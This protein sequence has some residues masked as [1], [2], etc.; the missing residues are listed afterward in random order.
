MK[1]YQFPKDPS[2]YRTREKQP[3]EDL[4]DKTGFIKDS[5]MHPESLIFNEY[6][7]IDIK[8]INHIL[9]FRYLGWF[10]C[11]EPFSRLIKKG[12]LEILYDY[13]SREEIF[14]ESQE[15]VFEFL[16]ELLSPYD[17]G[18]ML[19]EIYFFLKKD[20]RKTVTKVM[21]DFSKF[22]D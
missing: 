3:T 1:I 8:K 18:F 20:D 22:I 7:D 11:F 13:Y 9:M 6:S 2:K 10:S 15:V 14:N 21:S 5:A 19:K 4:S 16:I 17:C 12:N